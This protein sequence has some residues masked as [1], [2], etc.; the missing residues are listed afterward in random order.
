MVSEATLH[1]SSIASY[2]SRYLP[3][4]AAHRPERQ[5]DYFGHFIKLETRGDRTNTILVNILSV[6]NNQLDA[7]NN[8]SLATSGVLN[9][10]NSLITVNSVVASAI[11]AV[12]STRYKGVNKGKFVEKMGSILGPQFTEFQNIMTAP[13]KALVPTTSVPTTAPV[14]TTHL[15][16][17]ESSEIA[18]EQSYQRQQKYLASLPAQSDFASQEKK[19]WGEN[20]NVK[21]SDLATFM[22]QRSGML[23]GSSSTDPM[24]AVWGKDKTAPVT[25]AITSSSG[26][27]FMKNF[28]KD[29]S[30]TAMSMS[31]AALVMQ[32]MQQFMSGF[33]EPFGMIGEMFGA[34]G[35]ILGTMFY[36][37]LEDVMSLLSAGLPYAMQLAEW[38]GPMLKWVMDLILPFKA[39]VTMGEQ[40]GGINFDSIM[41]GLGN[42]FMNLGGT[43]LGWLVSIN[44][45][46]LGT[47]I[48]EWVGSVAGNIIGWL[49]TMDW[50]AVGSQ[51]LT[52]AGSF[53]G[54]LLTALGNAVVDLGTFAYKFIESLWTALQTA[55]T[56]WFG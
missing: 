26:G 16:V 5:H 50:A 13:K 56:S 53:I 4:I 15:T 38:L 9:A 43:I 48:G 14:P 34:Y 8:V 24:D 35:E 29:W 11:M 7:M 3:V 23:K 12:E 28:A 51:L 31:K 10:V 42:W 45:S 18:R 30:Q 36:P 49:V 6:S 25:K 52:W 22:E 19:I 37:I 39:I 47:Q 20:P 55:L 1:L 32:P 54:F 41:A 46:T 33:L 44:W 17:E 21:S 2:S 27:G 40:M